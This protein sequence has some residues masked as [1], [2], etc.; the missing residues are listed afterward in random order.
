MLKDILPK[1]PLVTQNKSFFWKRLNLKTKAMI[2]AIAIST[3]PVAVMGFVAYTISDRVITKQIYKAQEVNTINMVE[4]VQAFL[5]ERSLDVEYIAN[6]SIFRNPQWRQTLT[7]A[8]KSQEL[9]QIVKNHPVYNSITLIDLQGNDLAVSSGKPANHKDDEYFKAVINTGK[10]FIS[11]PIFSQAVGEKVV[12]FASPVTDTNTKQ[13]IG[14]LQ[15]RVPI[16]HIE[17]LIQEYADR[18]STYHLADKDGNVFITNDEAGLDTPAVEH[19]PQFKELR[20]AKTISTFEQYEPLEKRYIIGSYAAFQNTKYLPEQ[21]STL[22]WDGFFFTEENV[23]FIPQTK[24]GRAIILGT[25]ITGLIVSCLAVLV[26][27]QLVN[28]I[29]Q[30]T[31]IINKISQRDLGK[32]L[33]VDSTDELGMLAININLMAAQIEDLL[34]RQ[35]KESALTEQMQIQTELAEQ[36]RE[37]NKTMQKELLNFLASIEEASS[38]NLTVRANI[39]DD[40]I[41]IVADFFNSI[42]ESLRE[43]VAQVKVA[44]TQVNSS[45]SSNETAIEEVAKETLQQTEQINQALNQVEAMAQ[46][47]QEVAHNAQQAALVSRTAS[48]SA[49][50]GAQAIEETVN[51]I[52]QLRET[53]ASTAKKVKR[54]GESSQEISKVVSLINQIA[55]QTNLL[56]I[57][58]SIEASRAG[59]EGRG[60]AVVAE[61]VGELA[62]KSAE[63]TQEIEEIVE[64]IQEETQ[65]VVAA[66]EIGTSQV[67]EGTRLVQ[68]TK[69]SLDK[70]AEV[71]YQINSLLQSISSATISQAQTSQTVTKLME[72]V[73]SVSQRTSNASLNVSESLEQTV[74]I[75]QQLEASVDTFTV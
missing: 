32:K 51:S 73:A 68:N 37:R 13:I 10:S 14:V 60:F 5:Q 30:A 33:Q 38:G 62:T 4:K 48:S 49:E 31:T 12:Y 59:E 28:P 16:K 74:K 55:M 21:I 72:E 75:A 54:L 19:L 25:I 47:I 67:V 41:G 29:T 64:N 15:A 23:A 56:A 35:K 40:S 18:G 39:T 58:A 46:S 50:T 2:I 57:N 66:M 17:K 63:A 43:I 24:F 11:Q 22:G 61:E 27:N 9:A 71:S 53:I 1:H 34:D 7:V 6:L 3:I 44:S 70:I 36:E 69:D 45:I 26:A 8:Q 65:E 20:T 42:I 52:L